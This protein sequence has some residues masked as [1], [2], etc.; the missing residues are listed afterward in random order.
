MEEIIYKQILKKK[1]KIKDTEKEIDIL[2]RAVNRLESVQKELV[3]THMEK[4]SLEKLLCQKGFNCESCVYFSKNADYPQ[5]TRSVPESLVTD[6]KNE[7]CSYWS[8][9]EQ[10]LDFE[11]TASVTNPQSTDY[12]IFN[13]WTVNDESEFDNDYEQ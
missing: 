5:C 7:T 2:E 12:V 10:D 6:E 4:Q 11:E 3:K 9:V 8:N 13:H 1:E